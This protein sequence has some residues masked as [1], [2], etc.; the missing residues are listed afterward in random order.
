MVTVA[1]FPPFVIWSLRDLPL[2][3]PGKYS[4]VGKFAAKILFGINS[5]QPSHQIGQIGFSYRPQHRRLEAR[6]MF[7]TGDLN[8]K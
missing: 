8:L 4:T 7:K 3:L 2:M 1:A 6:G 5:D